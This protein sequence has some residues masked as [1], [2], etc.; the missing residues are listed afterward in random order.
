MTTD[1]PF[2][3]YQNPGWGSAIVEAQLAFYG[4][5]Y[6]LIEAGDL[7]EDQ[8]ARAAMAA[9][10]PLMQVPALVLPS[11]EVMTESAAITLYLAD[12]ARSDALVPGPDAAERAQFLR[13]LVCLVAAI[14]P[15]FIF[16]DVPERYVSPAEAG[17]FRARMIEQRKELWRV[18]EAAAKGPWF[19]GARF[20][21][22]DVYLACMVHWRPRK[23][24]FASEAPALRRIAEAAA[25]RPELAAVMARNFG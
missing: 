8:A 3:L 14:Y 19:L 1:A 24:W 7:F 15:T 13:W 18:V 25:A 12:V 23:D 21:A 17:A 5:P 22:I 16:A 20:S 4:L 11:G 2:Q 9:V 10:N 6:A